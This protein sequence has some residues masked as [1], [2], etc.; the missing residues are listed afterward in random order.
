MPIETLVSGDA[1]HFPQIGDTCLIHYV[2]FLDN[3]T[4]FDNSYRR[5]RPLCV[6]LG[7]DQLISGLEK[8]ILKMS[9]GMSSR[10]VLSPTVFPHKQVTSLLF[11]GK[12]GVL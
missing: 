5:D 3:G 12:K 10:N 8:T 11:Q 4:E 1:V 9:R 6:L 2:G 7:A